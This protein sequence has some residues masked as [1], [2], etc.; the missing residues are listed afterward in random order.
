MMKKLFRLALVASLVLGA[1][2]ASAIPLRVDVATLGVGSAGSWSLVGNSPENGSWSHVFLDSSSWEFD[3]LAGEYDWY[4]NGVGLGSLVSWSLT[5]DGH[6]ID[7]GVA[8]G[9]KK[10]RFNDDHSFSAVGVPEP[11]TLGLL[12]L[13]LAALGLVRRRKV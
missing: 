10:Y 9:Y 3:I 5:L 7:G 13:S 1:N 11:A 2:M 8:G 4:L 12:G 6:T